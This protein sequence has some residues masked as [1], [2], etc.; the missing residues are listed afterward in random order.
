MSSNNAFAGAKTAVDDSGV[1]DDYL[2]SGG[3]LPTDIYEATIKAAYNQKSANSKAMSIV[4][5]LVVGNKEIRSQV[6]ASNKNGGVT[7][8]DDKTGKDKN[9]PGYN[10][11]NTLAL[12]LTGKALGDL[13]V[14]EKTLNIYDFDAKKEVPQA[15]DCYVE[16]HG[17]K[18]QVALQKQIVDKTK[19]I[20]GTNP[21]EYEAVGV[22]EVNEVVKYFPA[23]KL[24]TMSEVAN[25]V[26]S[27]GE[28]FDG[29]ISAGKLLKVLAK[30]PEE[31]GNYADKWLKTNKDQTYDR[32]TF[33]G[34]KGEG[35]SFD[36]KNDGEGASERKKKTAGLFDD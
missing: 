18:V 7:Y 27:V 19:A 31:A 3:V 36:S 2:R 30:M 28:D 16:L 10:Q 24:V 29:L 4:V 35:K 17:E 14:E 12:L 13:D 20:A 32:S 9:I 23:D 8:K 15:V 34:E 5:I 26:K 21:V 1:E 22:R 25:W 33:K 6:W 11:M